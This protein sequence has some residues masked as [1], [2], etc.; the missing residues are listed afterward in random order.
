[1]K[2]ISHGK[3]DIGCI[4]TNNEDVWVALPHLGFFA[5]ADGMGGHN[6]GEV[7][8][9]KT[10]DF[11]I[12]KISEI[13]EYDIMEV[14]IELRYL[15]EK[16]NQHIHILGSS[17]PEYQGMGTTLCC[18]LWTHSAIVYAHVGDSRIYRFRD[19]KLSLLTQ[20]H[21]LLAKWLSTGKLAETCATPFPYKHV[22]TR[23]IGGS[24]KANP[25]IAVATYQEGDL[26]F[27]CSDGL[28]DAM[29]LEEMEEILIQEKNLE[30]AASLFIEKAKIKG[31]SDNM[32]IVMVKQ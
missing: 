27:L 19:N 2:F 12:S 24:G 1:M 25:E 8:A 21:S 30:N 7:A 23:S 20:D 5:I 9:Q 16:A 15:I 29:T 18:L 14:I 22:I 4:R 13:K 17:F 31:G 3:T 11:L 10:I 28:T 32:T 26:F 6:A